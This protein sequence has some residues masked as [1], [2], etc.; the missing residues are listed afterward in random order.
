MMSLFNNKIVIA[1]IVLVI[2]VGA[3]YGLTSSSTPT[4]TLSTT[5]ESSPDDQAVVSA[6]L[7]LQAISLSNQIFSNPA[8]QSLQDYTV[9]VVPEPVGR[10]DPFA[11]FNPNARSTGTSTT[12]QIV[13]GAQK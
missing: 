2:I 7:Q 9:Q 1:A 12:P 3:W 13:Q 8:F 10:T 5:T 4:P 6:L 11:P